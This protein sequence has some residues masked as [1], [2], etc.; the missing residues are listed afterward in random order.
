MKFL[1]DSI[2]QFAVFPLGMSQWCSKYSC[3][4]SSVITPVL[5]APYPTAQKCLPQYLFRNA[6]NSSCSNRELR[7]FNLFTNSLMLIDGGYSTC[8]CM[9]SLLTTPFNM[10]TSSLLH[11]CTKMSRHLFCT[12]PVNTA[13]RY[14]VTHTI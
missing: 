2:I 14:F 6:G 13:Y 7:P 8:I 9:W 5:Q 12:S 1:Y 4:I 10:C 11:T 3:T